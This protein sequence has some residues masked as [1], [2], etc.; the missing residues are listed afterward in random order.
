MPSRIDTDI[1]LQAAKSIEDRDALYGDAFTAYVQALE[2]AMAAL[3][4]MVR[5]QADEESTRMYDR[6]MAALIV[7]RKR[8][9]DAQVERVNNKAMYAQIVK[10]IVDEII[11]VLT[12]HEAELQALRS[13]SQELEHGSC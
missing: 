11:V 1:L 10:L 4:A 7:M 12:R 5:A 13:P 8:M 2:A 6:A 9:D 3:I